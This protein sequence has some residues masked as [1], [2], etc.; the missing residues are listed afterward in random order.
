VLCKWA[1]EGVDVSV[2]VDVT[3]AKLLLLLFAVVASDSECVV[4]AA[5]FSRNSPSPQSSPVGCSP[6]Q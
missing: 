4:C 2:G 1:L 5:I 3:R 6:K